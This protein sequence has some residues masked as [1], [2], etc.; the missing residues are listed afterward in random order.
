MANMYS[1]AN[2]E[3]QN[4]RAQVTALKADNTKLQASVKQEQARSCSPIL[5]WT[6]NSLMSVTF[7]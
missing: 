6:A 7:C 5:N 3:L 2:T 4:L 1:K